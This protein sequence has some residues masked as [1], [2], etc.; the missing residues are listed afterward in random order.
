M[1]GGP[2]NSIRT[3]AGLAQLIAPE[4]IQQTDAPRVVAPPQITCARCHA[5]V[6]AGYEW[7]PRCGASLRATTCAYCGRRVAAGLDDCPS[8]G[9][10]I[11]NR[12]TA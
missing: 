7:C 8:C 4:I 3:L 11:S 1:C 5:Q 10:P 12:A 2:K 6:D 9:A